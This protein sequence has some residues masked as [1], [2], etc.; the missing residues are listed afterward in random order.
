ME[1][2]LHSTLELRLMHV[3]ALLRPRRALR[4]LAL[5]LASALVCAAALI[6]AGAAAHERG[7]VTGWN[8]FASDL[9]AA[10]LAP[11]PQTHAGRTRRTRTSD[12]ADGSR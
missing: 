9:V 2:S 5:V 8:T 3:F 1:R 4:R 11:G 10:N 6:P 12:S 7:A